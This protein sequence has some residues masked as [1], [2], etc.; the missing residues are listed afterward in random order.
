MAE[1]VVGALVL[2]IAGASVEA[3]GKAVE[4]N[5]AKKTAYQQASAIEEQTA[6][7]VSDFQEQGAAI[8]SRQAAFVGA[9]GVK[10]EGSPLMVMQET[11]RQLKEDEDWL[12]RQG[13]LASDITKK[14]GKDA[15]TASMVDIGTT[16]LTRSAQL[17]GAF[18]NYYGYQRPQISPYTYSPTR[19][20][21]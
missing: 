19:R 8:K 17:Y 21:Y 20:Y 7:Q 18:S 3:I 4:G 2:G 5:E 14:Q 10:V 16:L 11:A 13:Q 9:S 1:I 6:K 12:K 15:Q